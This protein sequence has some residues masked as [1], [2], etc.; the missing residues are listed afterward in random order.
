MDKLRAER[1]QSEREQLA[2]E[3]RQ[4]RGD[5]EPIGAQD[6]YD[7][8]H[9]LGIEDK[10]LTPVPMWPLYGPEVNTT[11][12]DGDTRPLRLWW[13]APLSM[14]PNHSL[15]PETRKTYYKSLAQ[16]NGSIYSSCPLQIDVDEAADRLRLPGSARSP[17]SARKKEQPPKRFL[18][19]PTRGRPRS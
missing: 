16:A 3:R 4:D 13:E 12:P 1:E 17:R 6:M 19:H 14:R 11:T 2:A 8:L 18:G 7:H 5:N 9:T 15:T 10:V